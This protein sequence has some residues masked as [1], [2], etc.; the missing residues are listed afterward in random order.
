MK[1]VVDIGTNTLRMLIGTVLDKKIQVAAQYVAETRLGKGIGERR[2]APE[3]INRSLEAL[4][5]FQAKA[6]G[7]GVDEVIIVATSAVR[8]A[9]NGKEFAEKVLK[10]TGWPVRVLSGEEE[11]RLSFRGAVAAYPDSEHR[12]IVIDIGGGSTEIIYQQG[13][14]IFASSVNVGTVRLLETMESMEKLKHKFSS[15]TESITGVAGSIQAVGVGGTV[16]T[17]AA[18]I[19]QVDHYTR[20]EVHGKSLSLEEITCLKNRLA[21]MPFSER[22]TVLGLSPKRAD[23]IIPGLTILIVLLDLLGQDRIWVSDAGL[24]DGLLLE[25]VQIF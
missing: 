18:V 8:D 14:K 10:R 7:F 19:Y 11:A 2:L 4:E 25:D 6:H 15:V 5:C 9:E 24:L 16:T 21:Q 20:E 17:A 13:D 22:K 23:I 1:A 12:P 3:A